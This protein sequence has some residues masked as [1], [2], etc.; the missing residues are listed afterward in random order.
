MCKNQKMC[1]VKNTFFL[2]VLRGLCS[3]YSPSSLHFFFSTTLYCPFYLFI[4]L[5]LP[6]LSPSWIIALLTCFVQS[7]QTYFPWCLPA[8]WLSLAHPSSSMAPVFLLTTAEP[9]GARFK[10]SDAPPALSRH[11]LGHLSSV[12]P[13]PPAPNILPLPAPRRLF[14]PG[15]GGPVRGQSGPVHKWEPYC[16]YLLFHLSP[17]F[18]RESREATD[19]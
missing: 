8:A 4:S 9:S 19:V 6:S 12:H 1:T 17:P 10:Q 16:G 2:S 13:P 3:V 15:L 5:P 18:A 11:F 14:L 7:T